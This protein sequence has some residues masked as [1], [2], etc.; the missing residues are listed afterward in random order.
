MAANIKVILQY[1]YTPVGYQGE[2][3]GM[4]WTGAE[5][6]GS[7]YQ[8]EGRDAAVVAEE[9]GNHKLSRWVGGGQPGLGLG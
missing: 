7:H 2:G 9:D 4:L 8:V 3:V 6:G 1:I 5:E